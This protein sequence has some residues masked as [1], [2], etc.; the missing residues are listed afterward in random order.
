MRKKGSLSPGA[1]VRPEAAQAEPEG[2]C[3]L[4]TLSHGKVA[5]LVTATA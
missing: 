1:C 3:S 2:S 4:N 5:V